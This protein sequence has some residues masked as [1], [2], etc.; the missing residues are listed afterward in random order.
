M[1]TI[2][3]N[4]KEPEYITDFPIATLDI[5]SKIKESKISPTLTQE[6][7]KQEFK[8]LIKSM[9]KHS[10]LKIEIP[11]RISPTQKRF[12]EKRDSESIDLQHRSQNA[13]REKNEPHTNQKIQ[14]LENQRKKPLAS[15]IT[16]VRPGTNQ[17]V[18]ILAHEYHQ[19]IFHYHQA[20]LQLLPLLKNEAEK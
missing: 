7:E 14:Q 9:P 16:R 3:N 2:L 13:E 4:G 6:L 10:Q 12:N 5:T 8:E 1:G 18:Q 19:G 17:Q 20:H 11:D 15:A